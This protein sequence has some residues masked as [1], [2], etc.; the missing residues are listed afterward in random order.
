MD[1]QTN[2]SVKSGP[3]VICICGSTK[4]IDQ[5][6]IKRW[7][8]EKAGMAICLM[9]NYLPAWYAEEQ[10]WNEQDHFA[11]QAGVKQI[12]DDLHFAKIDLADRVYVIN[13]GGYIGESTR[14]EINYA[15]ATGKP[16]E[17]MEPIDE[18]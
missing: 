14:N 18:D 15:K 13:V 16:I 1:D 12:M 9:V 5:H 8:F 6:A 11:E 2:A 3:E 7:E 4:F 17:Y 10:G